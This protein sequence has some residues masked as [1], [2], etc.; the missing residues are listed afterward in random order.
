MLNRLFYIVVI[1]I[2]ACFP[3]VSSN[4][5]SLAHIFEVSS[6]FGFLKKLLNDVL[7]ILNE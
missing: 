1:F 3:L 4:E 7:Q 6:A 2:F 5:D